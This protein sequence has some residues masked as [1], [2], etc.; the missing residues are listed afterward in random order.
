MIV[1]P[2]IDIKGGRCVRLKQG[3][4]NDETVFSDRPHE[5]GIKWYKQGAERLHLVDLDGAVQGKPVNRD[6]IKRIE[7]SLRIITSQFE[8]I[9][10]LLIWVIKGLP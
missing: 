7:C 4:M 10:N 5:M 6:V 3:R 9:R 8:T 1:I 2:A